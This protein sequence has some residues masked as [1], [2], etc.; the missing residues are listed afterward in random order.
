M[1]AYKYPRDRLDRSAGIR[2][3]TS[4]LSN[5]TNRRIRFPNTM[6]TSSKC[7]TYQPTKLCTPDMPHPARLFLRYQCHSMATNNPNIYI[8]TRRHQSIRILCTLQVITSISNS[9]NN[10]HITSCHKHPQIPTQ[11]CI[12]T[13][14]G[15]T[16]QRVA[17]RIHQQHHPHQRTFSPFS[18]QSLTFQPRTLFHITHY[19]SQTLTERNS[20]VW[21]F[22]TLRKSP[23]QLRLILSWTTTEH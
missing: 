4:L 16:L 20:L 6:P 14:T 17:S 9:K 5:N 13:S 10:Q 18:I 1:M 8:K 22:T 3:L 7:S 15:I 21:A 19:Q 12:L 11:R 2:L 23:R